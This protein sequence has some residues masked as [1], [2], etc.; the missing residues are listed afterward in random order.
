M[1]KSDLIELIEYLESEKENLNKQQQDC[2]SQYDY[3]GAHYFSIALGEVNRQLE[4]LYNFSD[5]LYD[6]KQRLENYKSFLKVDSEGLKKAFSERIKEIEDRIVQLN[7]STKDQKL[8]G[9]EFDDVIYELI[10]KQIS[11]FKFHLKRKENCYLDFK[12][13]DNRTILVSTNPLD[14]LKDE[15]AINYLN[16]KFYAL[17]FVFN[18]KTSSMEYFYSLE[19]FKNSIEIKTL[20]SRIIFDIFYYKELDNPALIEKY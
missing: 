12:L 6:E 4:I 15:Y 8:D 16:D 2:L 17:G 14:H 20:T 11:G 10:E 13:Y 3:K 7:S 19:K 18:A 5:S 9:Q 1:N